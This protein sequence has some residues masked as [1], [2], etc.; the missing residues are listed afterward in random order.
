MYYID[1]NLDAVGRILMFFN[2]LC[3]WLIFLLSLYMCILYLLHYIIYL[4]IFNVLV[5][6]VSENTV[7]I[8]GIG[9]VGLDMLDW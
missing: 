9:H 4:K 6:K 7:V 1:Y 3:N 8:P 5:L 2:H